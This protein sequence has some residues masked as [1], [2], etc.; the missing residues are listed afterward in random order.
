MTLFRGWLDNKVWALHIDNLPNIGKY[1][2]FRFLGYGAM[3]PVDTPSFCTGA[4]TNKDY[5]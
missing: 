1:N 2:C 4:V 5:L 3:S